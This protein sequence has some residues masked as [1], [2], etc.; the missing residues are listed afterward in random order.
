MINFPGR[1]LSLSDSH[2]TAKLITDG[3][4]VRV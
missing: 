3:W 2:G 4:S 1:L